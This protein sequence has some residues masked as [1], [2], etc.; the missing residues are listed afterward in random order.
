MVE[1]LD[2]L[3]VGAGGQRQHH[4]AGAEAGVDAAVAELLTEQRAD[5]A[6]PCSADRRVRLRTRRGPGAYEAFS[7]WRRRRPRHRGRVRCRSCAGA[8]RVKGE[9][10]PA[11]ADRRARGGA[12][13]QA[14]RRSR[15]T[16]RTPCPVADRPDAIR[17]VVA[18]G[19][20]GIGQ[21]DPGRDAPGLGRCA[22]PGRHDGRRAPPCATSTRPS[23]RQQRSVGLALAPLVH[24]GVKVN[25]LDAP[26]LRR[27]RRASCGPGCGPPTARCS[28][29][30][31][32]RAST[33]RPGRCGAS[34]PRSACRASSW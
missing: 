4:V 8:T 26:G 3:E 13:W 7:P 21:D 30:P 25:L 23:M 11:V 15:P 22:E 9:R 17:N 14:S 16:G 33:S 24:D 28:C 10:A 27:L 31:P 6:R 2:D 1:H 20:R 29:S 18:G 32:T 12:T 34:A 5:A 19:P